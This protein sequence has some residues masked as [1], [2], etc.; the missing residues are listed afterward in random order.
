[1]VLDDKHNWLLK[2]RMDIKLEKKKKKKELRPVGQR[3]MVTGNLAPKASRVWELYRVLVTRGLCKRC[4]QS[5]DHR[6]WKGIINR[7]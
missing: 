4:G 5:Y 1:M 7:F 3:S 6:K 2:V